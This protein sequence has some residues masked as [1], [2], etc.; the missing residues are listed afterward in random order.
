VLA[1]PP[2]CHRHFLLE[3]GYLTE[4]WLTFDTLFVDQRA[5]GVNVRSH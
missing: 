1:G 2:V 3:S 5:I 4:S